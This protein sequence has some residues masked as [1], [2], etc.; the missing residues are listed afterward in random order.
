MFF[1]MKSNFFVVLFC[2]ERFK[3]E[4][5][6]QCTSDFPVGKAVYKH[7]LFSNIMF[8]FFLKLAYEFSAKTLTMHDCATCVKKYIVTSY[9]MKLR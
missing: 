5:K 1:S 9:T 2:V 6:I 7:M 8:F 3:S 4:Y